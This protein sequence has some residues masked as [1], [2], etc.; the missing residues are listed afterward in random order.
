M[1]PSTMINP[2]MLSR[3]MV[4]PI[5]HSTTNVPRNDTTSPAATQMATRQLRNSIRLISTRTSPA[6]PLRV[7]RS[8]RPSMNLARSV[9]SATWNWCSN[10]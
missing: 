5:A 10:G 8:S 4:S 1:I 2:N 7:I 3:L 9:C 6:R